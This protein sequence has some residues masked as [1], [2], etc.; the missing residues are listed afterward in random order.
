[1]DRMLVDSLGEVII[2]YDGAV[3]VRQ[4]YPGADAYRKPHV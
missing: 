4:K 1:M 2:T 3:S